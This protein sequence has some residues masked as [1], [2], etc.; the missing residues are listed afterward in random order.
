MLLSDVYNQLS[1]GELAHVFAST[2]KKNDT[3]IEPEAFEKLFPLIQIGLTD[4]HSRMYLREGS[5]QVPLVSGT[6]RYVIDPAEK[7]LIEIEQI[8]GLYENSL[9]TIT[10]DVRDDLSSIRRVSADTIVVPE[11]S[12]DAKWRLETTSLDI[13]YR[14][15]HPIINNYKANAAPL[16]TPIYLPNTHLYALCLG[17]ASRYMDPVGVKSE[18]HAGNN[19]RQ[20]YEVELQRLE[21]LGFDVKDTG[22]NNNLIR[23]GWA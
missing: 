23:N 21:M 10:M 3:G 5:I 13:I 12:D 15:N 19:Y 22:S 16:I 11:P 2:R 20:K 14:A 1:Y 7:D 17:V 18:F 4:L 8:N 9:Y 6:T